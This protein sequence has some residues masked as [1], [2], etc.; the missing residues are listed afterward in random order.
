MLTRSAD[1]RRAVNTE[2]INVIAAKPRK[3]RQNI[4]THMNVSPSYVPATFCKRMIA[5]I[6]SGRFTTTDLETMRKTKKPTPNL[7]RILKGQ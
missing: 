1:L 3:T 7:I 4:A 5:A 6:S 2:C